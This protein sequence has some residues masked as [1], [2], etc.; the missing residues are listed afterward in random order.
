MTAFTVKISVVIV[1]SSIVTSFLRIP[2]TKNCSNWLIFD[3]VI[4]KLK[5]V[6]FYWDT[7]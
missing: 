2:Y 1:Q 4:Q 6:S 5:S 3:R 7:L